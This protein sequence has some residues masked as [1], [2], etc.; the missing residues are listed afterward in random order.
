MSQRD[1]WNERYRQQG[2]VWGV[3]P[4]QFVADRLQ[5]IE[6]CRVLDL[7]S[8]HG[9][10]AIWLAQQG[11]TVTA[12][13]V[14]D[15]AT[16][17]GAQLSA[18]AGVAVEFV[19]TDLAAWEP[20]PDSYDLVL[21]AYL[22]APEPSRRLIHDKAATALAPGG[23]V[24]IVAHHRDNLEQGHGGPPMPEVLFD[25]EM[26]AADFPG[27]VVEENAR[28]LRRVEKDDVVANAIDIVFSAR[29]P[30]SRPIRPGGQ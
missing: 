9:R 8:G 25:E 29:K 1:L 21:L 19:T 22:Q 24:F 2:P 27:F 30:G 17:Q 23:L 20:E 5:G 26:L 11:H 15:V 4:N 3:A 10:N 14:S 7:G 6:P 28:V 16:D 13:D 12:I 18:D